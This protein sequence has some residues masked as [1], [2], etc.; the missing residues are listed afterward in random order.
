MR[1]LYFIVWWCLSYSL[2]LF[3]RKVELVNSPKSFFGRTIYVSNHA[4]SFMDPLVVACF[5]RPIVFF[6]TRS[7][8]FNPVSRPLL[9]SVHMLPIYRQLDGVNTKEKNIEVF[10]E[11]S[12]ILKSKRNLLIFGEGFTDDVFVRRLKPIKKGAVRI[13]FS[14]L[15]SINWS[16]KIYIAGVGCNYT[17]PNRMRSDLLISTSEQV[18]LNEFKDAYEANPNKVISELTI[19][20]EK[21]MKSQI[22]HVE[23]PKLVHL[24]ESIMVLTRK[25]M[26]AE[27]F[28]DGISL[29]SRFEYSRSLANWMNTTSFETIE[30]LKEVAEK[31]FN[32]LQMNHLTDDDVWRVSENKLSVSKEIIKVSVLLPFSILGIIHCGIPY[33][34]TK[35][36]VEKSFKRPVFWGSTKMLISMLL[37]G[38]LNIPII[39][40]LSGYLNISVWFGFLYYLLI[41]LFGLSAYNA[42]N[43]I[44]RAIKNLGLKKVVNTEIIRKRN[45]LKLLVTKIVPNEFH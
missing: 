35:K 45:D 23:N 30:P 28:D 27:S 25:G 8:V 33:W 19:K 16:E 3:F 26:N 21:L 24:H 6:M 40:I 10:N 22:T 20:V 39:F 38:L 1:P 17:E 41:G 15:E 7:D 37:I 11:C 13:G 4:A 42:M 32:T 5:R 9:W 29:K 12:K 2:R 31:Y 36:Y 43:F 18:C 44:K 34:L 14:A